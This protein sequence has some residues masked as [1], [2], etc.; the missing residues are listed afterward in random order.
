MSVSEADRN[1]VYQA[2]T[3]NLSQPVAEV[4]MELLFTKPTGELATQADLHANT[5]I[6]RGEFAEFRSEIRGEFTDFRSEINAEFTDFRN[7]INAEFTDFRNEVRREIVGVRA[8]IVDVRGEIQQ[9][10]GEMKAEIGNLYRWGAGI[11][12]ANGIAVVTALLT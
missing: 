10:R 3:T 1:M 2:F 5:T 12:V 6:L 8:D 9:L 11:M 7:E 4:I